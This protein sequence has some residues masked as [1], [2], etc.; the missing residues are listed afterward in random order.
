MPF[1]FLKIAICT[2]LSRCFIRCNYS[3][4]TV[5]FGSQVGRSWREMDHKVQKQFRREKGPQHMAADVHLYAGK[6]NCFLAHS[7]PQLVI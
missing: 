7:F 5:V 2:Y 1:L 4:S 6:N 3:F